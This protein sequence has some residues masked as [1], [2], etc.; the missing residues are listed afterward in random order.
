LA[1]S[2]GRFGWTGVIGGGGPGT[3]GWEWENGPTQAQKHPQ[4]R[5]QERAMSGQCRCTGG[6]SWGGPKCPKRGDRRWKVMHRPIE[7]GV[8][9]DCVDNRTSKQGGPRGRGEGFDRGH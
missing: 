5:Q 1:I 6:R 2:L 9:R 8:G 7:K 3:Q 4:G